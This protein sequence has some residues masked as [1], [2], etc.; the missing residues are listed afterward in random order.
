MPSLAKQE[1][2]V[3]THR[4]E[5]DRIAAI[6]GKFL[7]RYLGLEVMA[8]PVLGSAF[9]AGELHFPVQGRMQC[10][11]I[12]LVYIQRMHHLDHF[13]GGVRPCLD[14]LQKVIRCDRAIL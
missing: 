6:A 11:H 1:F 7:P 13:I 12:A 2:G 8:T 3:G 5:T 14:Q 10:R 9:G 4:I